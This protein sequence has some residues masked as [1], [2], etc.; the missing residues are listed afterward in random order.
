[1]REGTSRNSKV[2]HHNVRCPKQ[3]SQLF[4]E[5][6]QTDYKI[7]CIMIDSWIMSVSKNWKILVQ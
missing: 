1:M 5:N 7:F 3:Y 4:N 2:V 6:K